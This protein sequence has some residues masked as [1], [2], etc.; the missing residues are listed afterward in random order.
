M[1]QAEMETREAVGWWSMTILY[2][3]RNL[4]D[5]PLR[6]ASLLGKGADA[7]AAREDAGDTRDSIFGYRAIP[8]TAALA[9]ADS[10]PGGLG[11]LDSG[12]GRLP[13]G[14]IGTARECRAAG[15]EPQEPGEPDHVAEE[16]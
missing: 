4:P 2:A 13:D 16:A 3:D 1:T 15:V 6:P 5:P 7:D 10:L 8:I 14:R 12:W 9:A 11:T